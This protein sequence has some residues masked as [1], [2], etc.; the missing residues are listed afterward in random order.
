MNYNNSG[1]Y[2]LCSWERSWKFVDYFTVSQNSFNDG[3]KGNGKPDVPQ[4]NESFHG[5]NKTI[6]EIGTR[7]ES[8]NRLPLDGLLSEEHLCHFLHDENPT[9]PTLARC[10]VTRCSFKFE[11]NNTWKELAQH[12]KQRHPDRYK[13]SGACLWQDCRHE[14]LD[15]FNLNEQFKSHIYDHLLQDPRVKFKGY[16]TCLWR[17]CKNSMPP[18]PEGTAND[19][20]CHMVQHYREVEAARK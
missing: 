14:F 20:S 15:G 16:V 5:P 12:Y 1:G 3:C 4:G 13:L 11:V 9:P 8:S 7:P 19:F 10:P 17:E 2:S 6:M 18:P